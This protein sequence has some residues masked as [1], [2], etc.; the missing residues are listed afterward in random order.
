M[1]GTPRSPSQPL[2]LGR[3]IFLQLGVV[4]LLLVVSIQF[5]GFLLMRNSLRTS[6]KRNAMVSSALLAL[7]AKEAMQSGVPG[8]LDELLRRARFSETDIVY[9]V[10]FDAQGEVL[11]A[12]G[13]PAYISDFEQFIPASGEHHNNGVEAFEGRVL[14]VVQ[15]LE[16]GKAGCLHLGL[17][18]TPVDNAL[19]HVFLNLALLTALGLVIVGVI[20]WFCFWRLTRPI[21]ELIQTV[22]DFGGGQLSARAKERPESQDEAALLANVFNQMANQLE[23]QVGDLIRAK[24]DL[25]DEK[26]RVQSIVD[27]MAQAITLVTGDGRIAYC[28]Q[29]ARRFCGRDC[30]CQE[31]AYTFHRKDWPDAV[32]A[33]QDVSAGAASMRRLQGH[34]DGRDLELTMVPARDAEGAPLGIVEIVADTTERLSAWRSLAHAEKLNVVGQLAA[35]VAHEINSPLDG[36]IEASRII[37][38]NLHLPG[39]AKHFCQAQRSALER[40]ALIVRR[41]LTFSRAPSHTA[42]AMVRVSALLEEAQALLRHRLGHVALELPPPEQMFHTVHGDEISL[43]QVL[44]NLLNNAIDATPSGGRIRIEVKSAAPASVVIAV[45]DQGPGVS[46]EVE[47]KLFTP[48]FTTKELGKGTGLGL[49]VSLNIIQE[50][51][52]RIEFRNLERPWG[53]VFTVT[54]P[55]AKQPGTGRPAESGDGRECVAVAETAAASAGK[56]QDVEP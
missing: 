52:G 48:F 42:W 14:H 21:A 22:Q 30:Q 24:S 27:S 43:V 15:P 16:G 44:V 17:S 55:A 45:T 26:A 5:V 3:K 54:L 34:V 13:E 33:F 37:E 56:P 4:I 32:K 9:L 10:T 41:L 35:G 38:R 25:A 51:G 2:P 19:R 28:N 46:E 7:Q 29:A 53:A 49:A 18:W 40:I 36:A 50:H 39:K 20:A 12:D 6:Y 8:Q 11:S 1:S 23:G 47:A 31:R